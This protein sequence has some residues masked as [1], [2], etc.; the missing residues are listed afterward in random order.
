MNVITSIN[1]KVTTPKRIV[2]SDPGV[3]NYRDK[4]VEEDDYYYSLQQL[5]TPGYVNIKYKVN[6]EN[7]FIKLKK[8]RIAKA[9]MQGKVSSMLKD[10]HYKMAHWFC[11][12]NDI[13]VYPS[14]HVSEMVKKKE[15][16]RRRKIRKKTV[17]DLLSSGFGMFSERLIEVAE[18][19]DTVIIDSYEPYTSNTCRKCKRITI[20]G[21]K[22]I[23]TCGYKDCGLVCDRDENS[24]FLNTIVMF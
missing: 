4:D 23:F 3:L 8:A 10:A 6:D 14:F 17:K 1:N 2:G 5:F 16:R 11:D 9:R 13:V 7:C 21:S 12:N 20:I 24:S 19:T 15:K 18:K 22:E